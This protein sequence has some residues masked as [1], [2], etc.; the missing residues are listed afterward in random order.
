[1]VVHAIA[2]DKQAQTQQSALEL[3]RHLRDALNQVRKEQDLLAA[4]RGK[5]E[6][7]QMEAAEAVRTR[8]SAQL[9][10]AAPVTNGPRGYPYPRGIAGGYVPATMTSAQDRETQRRRSLHGRDPADGYVP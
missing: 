6:A 1:M 4:V 10:A 7:A 9:L 3:R 5:L 8:P 2:D